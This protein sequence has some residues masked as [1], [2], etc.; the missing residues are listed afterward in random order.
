MG[1]NPD[2]PVTNVVN[3]FHAAGGRPIRRYRET[4]SATAVDSAV[5]PITA[6]GLRLIRSFLLIG[7]SCTRESIIN[8]V[9]ELAAQNSNFKSK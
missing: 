5:D 6:D 8:I 2:K 7:N 1:A 9:E 4:L 3:L